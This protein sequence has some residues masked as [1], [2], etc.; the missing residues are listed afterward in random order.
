MALSVL[1]PTL[2]ALTE[3][4]GAELAEISFLF[5][6]RS[7]GRIVGALLG[8]RLLDRFLRH[9]GAEQGFGG[10]VST[11]SLKLQLADETTP[12]FLAAAFWGALTLGRLLAI[13]IAARVRPSRIVSAGLAAGMASA[14]LLLVASERSVAAPWVST[15]GLGISLAPVVPTIL[16]L[17]E[18]RMAVTGPV[19]GWFFARLGLGGMTIPL[20]I[21]QPFERIGPQSMPWS[22]TVSLTLAAAVLARLLS[23]SASLVRSRRAGV[24]APD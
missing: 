20:L 10:W 15:V 3:R 23:Y 4:T 13:P 1:G 16:A 19:T 18:R 14:T 2:P 22:V 24:T 17:V 9:V 11:Y 12:A 6:A 21:G 5:T 8:G 7:L